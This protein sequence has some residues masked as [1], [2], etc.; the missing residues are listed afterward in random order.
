MEIVRLSPD[1]R[2]VSPAAFGRRLTADGARAACWQVAEEVPVAVL[3]NGESFAVL[4]ATPSDLEDLAVG[5]ALTE[6]LVEDIARIERLAVAEVA[7]GLAIN[8]NI[9]AD[10]AGAV[11]G[12]RR[13]LPA[14]SGCGVCGAVTIAAALPAP[15]RVAPAAAPSRDALVRAFRAF[16]DRQPMRRANRS[17]HAAAFCA[18][19]GTIDTVREDVGRHNALDKLAGALIAGGRDVA[20][21]FVLLSSRVSV[22][23][24]QKTAALGVPFLAAVSAPTALALALARRAGIAVAARAGEDV[25]VFDGEGEGGP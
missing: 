17:T 8:L 25:V 11:N 16:P 7:D 5:F 12:R 18:A 14:R 19:D 10:R 15:P 4:M 1:D 22:E 3:L 24:V 20:G 9:P 13:A 2:D 21:G 23:M 6:G